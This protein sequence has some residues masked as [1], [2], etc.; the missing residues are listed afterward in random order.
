MVVGILLIGL[1][2]GKHSCVLEVDAIKLGVMSGLGIG[3]SALIS[4][5]DKLPSIDVRPS[6]T[7]FVHDSLDSCFSSVGSDACTVGICDMHVVLSEE[8]YAVKDNGG[9]IWQRPFWFY[10]SHQPP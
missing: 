5:L 7:L 8:E 10:G 9:E 6:S 1:T 2:D 4:L 3:K